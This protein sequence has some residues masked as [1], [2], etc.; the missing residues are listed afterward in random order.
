MMI[1]KT[2]NLDKKQLAKILIH[3]I[4]KNKIFEKIDF[5]EPGFLN[6]FF[7]NTFWMNFLKNIYFLQ[8]RLWFQ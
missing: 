4:L 8:K 2:L 6:I 5:V 1:S 3:E 7:S